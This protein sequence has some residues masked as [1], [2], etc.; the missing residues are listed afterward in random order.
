VTADEEGRGKTKKR[1]GRG[2]SRKPR[3]EMEEGRWK[4]G[5]RG[6]SRVDQAKWIH[7]RE[8]EEGSIKGG[9]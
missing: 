2:E 7:R 8:K 6:R 5:D 4:R 1:A 3:W 9:K